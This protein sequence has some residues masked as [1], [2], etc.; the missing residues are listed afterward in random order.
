[1]ST[2]VL[3]KDL[4]E[5]TVP[6]G[7][8]A[9]GLS[10]TT[11][12]VLGI[13]A[14]MRTTFDAITQDFPPELLAFIGGEGPGGYVVGELFHLIA[15][16]ALVAYAVVTGASA[17]AGEEERGTLGMLLGLPVRR[18]AVLT[19]KT[20]GLVAAVVVVTAAFAASVLVA[21]VLFGVGLSAG[22]VLAASVHLGALALMFGFLA[23]AA[24]AATGRPATAS[25][26]VGGLALVCY[27][28]DAMLPLADLAGWAELSP[29]FYYAG[30]EPLVHGVSPGHLAVLVAIGVAALVA[31]RLAFDRRDLRG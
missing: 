14:G 4:R 9:L 26:T 3:V 7:G 24:G 17:T 18:T 20:V 25:G 8:L 29:W 12:F 30:S 19:G 6:G 21:D 28:A 5:R 11:I 10:A 27:L 22:G 31:A 13:Y 23:L 2:D 1:M 15:P 16:A